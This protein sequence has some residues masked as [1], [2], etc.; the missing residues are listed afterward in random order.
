MACMG[1]MRNVYKILVRTP[2]GKRPLKDLSAHGR[3]ILEWILGK[4]QECVDWVCLAEDRDKWWALVNMIMNL[5]VP[6]RQE[7]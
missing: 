1:E 2:E 7:I 5:W 3:I 6:Y 4:Q